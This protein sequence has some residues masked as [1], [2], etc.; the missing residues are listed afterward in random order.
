LP[1]EGSTFCIGGPKV[2]GNAIGDGKVVNKSDET[3]P[4]N[5]SGASDT[6]PGT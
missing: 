4:L 1:S 2:D 6:V 3:G 5:K